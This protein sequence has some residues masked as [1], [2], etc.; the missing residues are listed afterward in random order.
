MEKWLFVCLS[1]YLYAIKL[2]T[3]LREIRHKDTIKFLG[4]F[5]PE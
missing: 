3:D 5:Y 1:V 2:L 4:T